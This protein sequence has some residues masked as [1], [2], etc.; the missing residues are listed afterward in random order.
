W[1]PKTQHPSCSAQPALHSPLFQ[2]GEPPDVDVHGESGPASSWILE[3]LSLRLEARSSGLHGSPGFQSL[4]RSHVE[5]GESAPHRSRTSSVVSVADSVF[6]PTEGA[7]ADRSPNRGRIRAAQGPHHQATRALP[8]TASI[9]QPA[10]DRCGS[11][12]F[13]GSES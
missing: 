2:E 11:I 8:P 12:H 1:P 9:S 3:R 10:Q 6:L 5:L 7:L 4:V 13:R